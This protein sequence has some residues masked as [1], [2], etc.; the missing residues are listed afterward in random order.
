MS[1]KRKRKSQKTIF[2]DP[3]VIAGVVLALLIIFT[4]WP[5]RI[6]LMAVIAII[7]AYFLIVYRKKH[8]QL[9]NLGLKAI[10][11]MSGQEF[12]KRLWV[13]FKDRG[14]EVKSTPLIGDWGADLIL[15]KNGIR[16]VVQAKRYSKSVGLAAVQEAHTAKATYGCQKAMVI[17]NAS[18]TKG[19][20]ELA[21]YNHV[22]LWDREKLAQELQ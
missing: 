19:A 5:I 14:Y 4:D 3:K 17:T 22:E 15:I 16:T 9:G 21:R 8:V 2:D 13:H 6:L 10:D 12:E 1:T 7:V 20:K 11:V 18:F